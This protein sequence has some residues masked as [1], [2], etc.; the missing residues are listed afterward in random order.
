MGFF[1]EYKTISE[2]LKERHDIVFY[3]ESRHYYQ[4]FEQLISGLGKKNDETYCIHH[5]RQKRSIINN[6]SE[7]G[8]SSVCKVDDWPFIFEAKGPGNGNDYAGPR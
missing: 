1:S 7:A 8:K 6:S 2:L 3:S 4:Y 5:I